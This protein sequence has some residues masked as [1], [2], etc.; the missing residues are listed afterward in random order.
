MELTHVEKVLSASIRWIELVNDEK[1][2]MK[3]EFKTELE[4]NKYRK[5]EI[6]AK[7]N[8]YKILGMSIQVEYE[9]GYDCYEDLSLN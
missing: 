8:L 4:L 9:K 7:K 2:T 1:V 6:E 3:A 5:K